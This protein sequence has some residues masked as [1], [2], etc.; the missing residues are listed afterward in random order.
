MLYT[1]FSRETGIM[2]VMTKSI[3]VLK[4]YSPLLVEIHVSHI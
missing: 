1:V 4:C 2:L 3:E